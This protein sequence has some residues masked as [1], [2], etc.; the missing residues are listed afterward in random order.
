QHIHAAALLLGGLGHALLEQRTGTLLGGLR[1]LPLEVT[2]SGETPE[3]ALE[4]LLERLGLG[5]YLAETT[6][7]GTVQHTMTHR[8]LTVDVFGLSAAYAP[9]PLDAVENA[10]LSRLDHKA[11]ALLQ[12]PMLLP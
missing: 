10:A 12:A 4:R 6:P 3:Q 7:L 11:L 1:G 8:R 5:K 2:Q 9:R